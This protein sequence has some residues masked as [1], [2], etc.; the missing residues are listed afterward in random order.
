VSA[1]RDDPGLAPHRR[2]NAA[3]ASYSRARPPYP[4]EVVPWL[5]DE[6]G[7]APGAP[8]L[9]LAAG[10]G[11]LTAPLAEAGLAVTAVEPSEGMRAVLGERAPDAGVI[12]ALAEDLPFAD[13]AFE[14][15]TV[16]NAWHWFDP[17]IAHAEIRRVL[18]PAG[19]LAVLWNVEDRSDPVAQRLDDVKLRVLDRSST[20]GPHE[21][22]PLGWDEHFER[23]AR[24]EFHFVHRPPS[25]DAYVASWSLV[26]NMGDDERERFLE[27]I[28]TWAPPGPV[29]LPFRV[30]ATL[31]RPTHS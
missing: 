6:A 26:A 7:L 1:D 12:D 16:A 29:D 27:E 11:A 19:C 20:P 13:G 31:G 17:A 5:V 30:T 15:V 23:I 14:L 21:E 25:V 24:R 4:P 18:S 8:A 28:R 2:F 9:D 3:A 22:E 10:T